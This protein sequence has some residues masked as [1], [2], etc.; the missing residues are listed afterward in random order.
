M[1]SRL[2]LQFKEFLWFLIHSLSFW[3]FPKLYHCWEPCLRSS[4]ALFI[5][6]ATINRR[7][8]KLMKLKLICNLISIALKTQLCIFSDDDGT[9]GHLNQQVHQNSSTNQTQKSGASAITSAF[10]LFIKKATDVSCLFFVCL[11]GIINVSR[12]KKY[13]WC[14]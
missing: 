12:G 6:I 9:I 13:V 8:R 5:Q 3:P 4:P 10:I 1:G 11:V 14:L 7:I 2:Q